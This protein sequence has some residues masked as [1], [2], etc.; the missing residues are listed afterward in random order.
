MPEI[1][2]NG[3]TLRY[4][5]DGN[6][7]TLLM[8]HS[9]GTNSYL[10]EGQIAA[11]KDRFTCVAI[12]ARGHGGS[13]NNGGATMQAIAE[14]AHAVLKELDLLPAHIMGISM[15]GLQCAR[16]HALTPDD[17]LSIVYA[18]SF[19]FLGDAGPDRVKAM[20]TMLAEKSM[21]DYAAFYTGDTL[22][23]A[24]AKQHHDALT[25]AISGMT[26][27][28]Y[29]DCVRSVFTED[30]REQLKAIDKPMHIV[31]GE[32]DQRTPPAAAESVHALVKGSSLEIIPDAA[33]LSNIDNPGGF[34]A[35]VGP[36]LDRI[37]T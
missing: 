17:V 26:K 18:D 6:G 3:E 34:L 22:L 30:V 7:P 10:W 37:R 9:L 12:D 1:S 23:P 32:K 35:A 27:E 14:D 20:E 21:A 19:A 5:R 24:T 25:A 8:L 31:T 29:L 13:T 28:N 16:L 2:V 15:G 4:R 36:F 33:H 11:L